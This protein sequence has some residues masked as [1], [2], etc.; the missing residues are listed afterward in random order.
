MFGASCLFVTFVDCWMFMC[1]C[2]VVLYYFIMT[3]VLLLVV[4]FDC[5]LVVYV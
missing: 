5:V 2:Y 1:A 3:G 4:C